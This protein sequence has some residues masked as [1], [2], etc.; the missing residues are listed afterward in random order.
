MHFPRAARV[1]ARHAAVWLAMACL[2]HAVCGQAASGV[3]PL[4]ATEALDQQN[5]GPNIEYLADPD[6]Q[7]TISDI[8]TGRAAAG[9]RDLENDNINF[10]Y[11]SVGYWFRF[12][13]QNPFDQDIDLYLEARY[14]LLDHVRLH[15]PGADGTYLEVGMGDHQPFGSRPLRFNIFV[16]R[17]H[18]PAKSTQTFYLHVRTTSTFDVPLFVSATDPFIEHV[19]D[20]QWVLGI[21]YGVIF[22]L[23]AY[24]LFIYLSTREKAF[25]FYVLYL[26]CTYGYSSA[27]DGIHF[28]MFPDA[29]GWQQYSIYVSANSS[30]VFLF[31]FA[32]EYLA[33]REVGGWML[34]LT[35]FGLGVNVAVILSH[36]VLDITI[37]AKLA[38]MVGILSFIYAMVIGVVRLM[39]GYRAARI[40]VLSFGVF[41]LMGIVAMLAAWGILPIF[42][43][44]L[45][46]FKITILLQLI[47]LSLA[48]GDR[49]NILKEREFKLEKEAISA[50]AESKATS[51]FLAKMSHEIRTPMNGVMGM[52]ELLG[53]TPLNRI[54]SHYLNVI[55]SSGR[56]LLG[57]INDILDYSKIEAGK[58]ELEEIDFNLEELANEC[59]SVF[60]L[61]ADEKNLEFV[62]SIDPETPV[63]L[64]GDPTRLR[65][66]ILNLMGNAFKFTDRGHVMLKVRPVRN[67]NNNPN[68]HFEISDTGIGMTEDV[69]R[70][71]FAS[72]TQ[73]DASTSRKYGGTGL[74][75]AI[76]KQLVELMGGKIGVNSKPKQG[77]TFWFNIPE[78]DALNPEELPAF[79]KVELGR[80]PMLIVDDQ[81]QFCRVM[82][83]EMLPLGVSVDIAPSGKIVSRLVSKANERG[84]PYRIIAI[85]KE[86]P[87]DS[88][89]TVARAISEIVD[90]DR[91]RIILMT[92][93]RDNEEQSHL[94]AAGIDM[95]INKPLSSAQ[96]RDV[97][98]LLLA[99][100][101]RRAG[102]RVP[103]EARVERDFSHL[104]VLVVEDNEVNLMVI[105]GMLKKISLEADTA[106]NGL[107]AVEAVKQAEQPYDLVLMD[108]EMPEMDGYDA[109]RG[110]RAYEA[111]KALKESVIIALSAHVMAE[112]RNK[113]IDAGMNDHMSKPVNLSVLQQK[114]AHWFPE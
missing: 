53:D 105:R 56:A 74:G 111:Q 54:Q 18:I 108:C 103:A 102:E 3:Q 28:R 5:L 110:I 43:L 113:S 64:R 91:T 52:A 25:L 67:S 11:T 60:S 57:V 32:I 49:I 59:V 107:R 9:F 76:S 88:G 16:D 106:T 98:A 22:G 27:L 6:G 87:D 42:E 41:I 15:K 68:I 90:R 36:L 46:G 94:D 66:V 40:Y 31:L 84:D 8:L 39:H 96:F 34:R 10:G 19:H 35:R 65:Q 95:A 75:L 44:S 51:D 73:A 85:N 26:V 80:F 21:F 100:A 13:I 101:P 97:L 89:Y 78:V 4:I 38:V 99:P 45:Y 33:L 48:L 82:Q 70:K 20:A 37:T 69:R 93:L 61:K 55:T 112:S 29:V 62:L 30:V 86:L 7:L 83:E 92:G 79:R 77:S 24:N 14:P 114:L 1:P 109:T 71:L 104:R 2:F 50:H 58:M 47:L 72:F 63:A 12:R 23:I 81:T 17:L